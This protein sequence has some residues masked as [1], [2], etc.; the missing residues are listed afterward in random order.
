MTKGAKDLFEQ[1]DSI[2]KAEM[3]PAYSSSRIEK[4][5]DKVDIRGEF[6]SN[7]PLKEKDAKKLCRIVIEIVRRIRGKVGADAVEK[8]LRE[9]IILPSAS[10]KIEIEAIIKVFV[11]YDKDIRTMR[12]T[13]LRKLEISA[14]Q[15]E[16]TI[17]EARNLSNE[18]L[19]NLEAMLAAKGKL[20][21]EIEGIKSIINK[22]LKEIG[23]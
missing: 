13:I 19:K 23:M 16:V 7:E 22:K 10:K 5:I 14:D 2:C 6:N 15:T 18:L 21:H 1:I 8:R 20:G 12:R 9:E 17:T 11:Y 3:G 4:A